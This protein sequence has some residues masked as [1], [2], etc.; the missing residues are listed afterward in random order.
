VRRPRLKGTDVGKIVSSLRLTDQ[1]GQDRLSAQQRVLLTAEPLGLEAFLITNGSGT[2]ASTFRSMASVFIGMGDS[3]FSPVSFNDI[4]NYLSQSNIKGDFP[5]EILRDRLRSIGAEDA[6]ERNVIA[7][8]GFPFRYHYPLDE[9]ILVLH[10]FLAMSQQIPGSYIQ[11]N[12]THVP[13]KEEENTLSSWKSPKAGLY[14]DLHALI[15]NH[16]LERGMKGLIKRAFVFRDHAQLAFLE[17]TGI[18]VILEQES[19][20]IQTGFLLSSERHDRVADITWAGV[21]LVQLLHDDAEKCMWFLGIDKADQSQQPY[22]NDVICKWHKGRVLDKKNLTEKALEEGVHIDL[23]KYLDLFRFENREPELKTGDRSYRFESDPE[24]FRRLLKANYHKAFPF[25]EVSEEEFDQHLAFRAIPENLEQLCMALE[26][27]KQSFEIKAI[28]ASSVKSTLRVHEADPNYRHWIRTTVQRALKN[29]ETVSLER[30]YILREARDEYEIFKQEI[31]LYRDLITNRISRLDPTL[32][33]RETILVSRDYAPVNIRLY[34]I[35][36]QAVDDICRETDEQARTALGE[37]LNEDFTRKEGAKISSIMAELDF[38]YSEKLVFNYKDYKGEPGRAFYDADLFIPHETK[39]EN[40]IVTYLP[41]GEFEERRSKYSRLFE[42]LKNRSIQ[43][44]PGKGRDLPDLEDFEVELAN[45][46]TEPIATAEI[47]DVPDIIDRKVETVATYAGRPTIFVSYASDDKE[48]V[49]RICAGLQSEGYEVWEYQDGIYVGEHPIGRQDS[50][51]HDCNFFL[52]C[53]S[54]TYG[55]RRGQIPR[56]I[57]QALERQ[58]EFIPGW[59]IFFLLAR[60]DDADVRQDLQSRF[61][62]A[63]LFMSDLWQELEWEKLLKSISVGWAR[64]K[65]EPPK[66]QQ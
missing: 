5:V 47:L 49:T 12:S 34:A 24:G 55:N 56:E 8:R 53:W 64:R 54:H 21:L 39:I 9:G 17:S 66:R 44:L 52:A 7:D 46:N 45:R 20:G 14:L 43:V 22:V 48:K 31:D 23:K 62:Y 59:D 13:T 33:A 11:I 58:D 51:I 41:T 50:A 29:K 1:Q 10:Y 57:K 60:L 27:I 35:T 61:A 19:I 63:S 40:K 37:L 65:S 36:M 26:Q 38:L 30:V 18:G 25:G 32:D 16:N 2:N 15:E 28:D 4:V 6:V 3:F 42:I